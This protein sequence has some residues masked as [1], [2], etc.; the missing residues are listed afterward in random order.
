[1][2]RAA[3][4]VKLADT[5]ALGAG[6]ARLGGS[7]PS[8]RMTSIETRC[9]SADDPVF[10]LGCGSIIADVIDGRLLPF[11][12]GHRILQLIQCLFSVVGAGGRAT[13]PALQGRVDAVGGAVEVVETVAPGSC[14][15]FSRLSSA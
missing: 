6:A 12:R 4:V 13:P 11:E 8:A 1:M 10:A 15:A 7:S 3:G 14:S 2:G 5:P 9:G